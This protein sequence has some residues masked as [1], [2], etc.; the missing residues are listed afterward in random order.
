[1]EIRLKLWHVL[2]G[3]FIIIALV[4]FIFSAFKQGSAAEIAK[5]KS[6]LD[7]NYALYQSQ[8][9]AIDSFIVLAEGEKTRR[10]EIEAQIAKRDSAI[11]RLTEGR[12]KLL[13]ELSHEKNRIKNLDSLGQYKLLRAKLDSLLNPT[14]GAGN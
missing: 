4:G 1:M 6:E 9:K 14:G 8:Q 5:L 7:T 11:I 10:V 2:A 12:G 3:L 13:K